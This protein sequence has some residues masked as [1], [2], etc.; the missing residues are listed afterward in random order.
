M[1]HT[2]TP[3]TKV[4]AL[5]SAKGTGCIETAL[6]GDDD[7]PENR[8]KVEATLMQGWDEPVPGTWTDV[9]DNDGFFMEE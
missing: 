6:Y 4:V 7:T 5:L 2:N 8:A 1:T 9:T 3:R